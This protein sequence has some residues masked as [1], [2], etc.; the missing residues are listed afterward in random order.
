MVSP[1]IIFNPQGL[2]DDQVKSV[3]QALEDAYNAGYETAKK[4]YQ[5]KLDTTTNANPS[6][7]TLQ[8]GGQKYQVTQNDCSHGVEQGVYPSAITNVGEGYAVI[9]YPINE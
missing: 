3:R 1:I 5:L 4:Q 7:N 9:G 6:P 8:W 2:N